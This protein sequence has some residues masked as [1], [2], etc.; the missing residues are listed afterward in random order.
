MKLFRYLVFLASVTAWSQQ[1]QVI[2]GISGQSITVTQPA[3][4]VVTTQTNTYTAGMKQVFT[5][6][7]TTAGENSVGVTVDPSALFAGDFWFRSD[8]KHPKIYDGT[9]AQLYMFQS[10]AVSA[11]QM[12]ALA[13]DCTSTAGSLSLICTKTNGTLFG[14]LAT[15]GYP[16]AGLVKSS[17][18]AFTAP[19]SADIVSLF[20]SGS[21]SGYLKNDG[22]CSTPSAGGVTSFN[23]RTGAIVPAANDY[24]FSQ[25]SG[26]SA[27]VLNNQNNTFAAN[28][29]EA[30]N[31][32][33]GATIAQ[34]QL[35]VISGGLVNLPSSNAGAYG[36]AQAAATSGNQVPVCTSGVSSVVVDN[37][38][39]LGNLLGVSTATFGNGVDLAT[40]SRGSVNTMTGIVGPIV[41][42][43]TGAGC[44]AKVSIEGSSR[45]GRQIVA[46][47]V[48]PSLFTGTYSTSAKF[49]STTNT[50][51]T[52]AGTL[53]CTDGAG[54]ATTTSCTVPSASTS[55]RRVTA[56]DTATTSDFT[57][58][59]NAA[60]GGFTETL[61]A[62]PA[63]GFR[64][65]IKRV[66][67]SSGNTLTV[68]GNGATVEAS[69]IP[70]GAA[71]T[72]QYESSTTS[73]WII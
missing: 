66:D 54:N 42:A 44:T 9:T 14:A 50:L 33:A 22:T 49:F 23:T 38:V 8:L 45:N 28:T 57:V 51:S 48:D 65:T 53:V 37:T 69:T 30:I 67:T 21:C 20:G 68:S 5:P 6:S 25:L 72:Y 56:N 60:G 2:N 32:T 27:V 26:T 43:C 62:S 39:V 29:C 35:I 40:S 10:D 63:N 11:A 24:S 70:P 18:S 47:T 1:V 36:I 3:N 64:L 73:W 58:L 16:A 7:S 46:A 13:G 31:Y 61:P 12:P 19:T 55:L 15:A 17:G 59:C 52:T 41:T 4:T 71:I 34:Y